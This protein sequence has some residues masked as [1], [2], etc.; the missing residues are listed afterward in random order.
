MVKTAQMKKVYFLLI[1]S[2]IL[3]IAHPAFPVR[4]YAA[5]QDFGSQ[6]PCIGCGFS[7]PGNSADGDTASFTRYNVTVAVVGTYIYQNLYFLS[8]SPGAD[9]V[10]IKVEDD[11]LGLLDVALLGNIEITSY[12]GGISNGDTKTSAQ[13]GISLFSG[14]TTKYLIKFT[15]CCV[16]DQI[17]IKM[18]RGILGTLSKMRF[19]YVY[20]NVSP[21]PVELVYFRANMKEKIA[22]LEWAT[23]TETNNSHF[24][25]E[26]SADG[27]DF[28]PLTTVQGSGTSLT[29]STYKAYDEKVNGAS[30]YRLKQVDFNGIFAYSQIITIDAKTQTSSRVC[31]RTTRGDFLIKADIG[32]IRKINLYDLNGNLI[33][34]QQFSPPEETIIE[35]DE[36]PSGLCILSCSDVSGTVNQAFY[37]P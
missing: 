19:Y 8:A 16:F 15:P 33:R 24:V 18:R 31:I 30:Y 27:R 11:D 2:L 13:M 25:V 17:Q 20:Y 35:L 1:V 29:S 3:L 7:N 14:T 23:A 26:K 5:G 36:T 12:Y 4:I 34:S 22:E 21:L 9:D 10:Y 32:A 6:A 28:Y 37:I